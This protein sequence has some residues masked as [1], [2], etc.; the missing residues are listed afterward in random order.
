MLVSVH[1]FALLPFVLL[2]SVRVALPLVTQ[3][4]FFFITPSVPVIC[5]RP[6]LIPTAA[7]VLLLH[8][9]ASVHTALATLVVSF[10]FLVMHI[11][12]YYFFEHLNQSIG[13]ATEYARNQAGHGT[14]F[15][16][17]AAGADVC[18]GMDSA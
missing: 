7:K 13:T 2:L 17:R 9:V 18:R 12:P 6:W 14:G 16:V 11:F 10:F 1:V 15:Y 3:A 5:K 4:H 8:V